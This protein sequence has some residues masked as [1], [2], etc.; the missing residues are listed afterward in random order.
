MKANDSEPYGEANPEQA[1]HKGCFSSNQW[2][3][4]QNVLWVTR[5]RAGAKE[6]RSSESYLGVC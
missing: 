4:L 5:S 1:P 6:T 3:R 2:E